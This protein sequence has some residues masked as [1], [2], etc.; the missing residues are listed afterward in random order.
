MIVVT[1]IARDAVIS[2]IFELGA[3]H[4]ILKPI[5]SHVL[6]ERV[7]EVLDGSRPSSAAVLPEDLREARKYTEDDGGIERVTDALLR[8]GIPVNLNGFQYLRDAIM[9]AAERPQVMNAV[10]KVLYPTVAKMNNTTPF[11]VERS[12]RS[13]ISIAWNRCRESVIERLFGG[14]VDPER[15]KPTNSEF[16]ALIADRVRIRQR[17]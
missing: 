2:R 17:L 3:D 13:A 8:L 1:G 6:L 15:G 12:I 16:I 10:T 11:R 14:T 4:Y 9:I 7:H 5:R